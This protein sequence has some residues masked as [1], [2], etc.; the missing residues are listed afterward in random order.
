MG[1]D[2]NGVLGCRYGKERAQTLKGEFESLN[3]KETEPLDEFYMKLNGLVTNIRA[4]GEKVE[5]TYVVK[6]LLRA[7]P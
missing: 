6:K 1:S 2:Q 5:E 7:V 3:M 4:L